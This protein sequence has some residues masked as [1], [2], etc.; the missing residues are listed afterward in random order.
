[1][2][3]S[4]MTAHG[5]G[6]TM[7][8]QSDVMRLLDETQIDAKKQI[9]LV[10]TIPTA[11][12]RSMNP[13]VAAATHYDEK[14]FDW[15]NSGARIGAQANLYN[16]SPHIRSEDRVIDFGC[17]AGHL[18]SLIKC[19]EKIGVEINPAA[20]AFATKSGIQTVESLDDIEDNWADTII[21]NH[22]LEHCSDPQ[23]VVSAMYRKLKVGGKVVLA[24]PH[25]RYVPYSA[26]D[27]NKHLY[28]WSAM[29]LGNLFSVCGFNVLD[30]REVYHR[31]PPAYTSIH[32]IFG[33]KLFHAIAS[34]YGRMSRAVTQVKI[35]ASK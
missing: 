27:I 32:K 1:M 4:A 35:V 6:D 31:F 20:R 3:D 15:Q 5:D 26:N 18:L 7:Q 17:G 30:V 13:Q 2:A 25:E 28:T 12:S 11:T 10:F 23:S 29:N 21:S 8:L 19:A 16:F 22:A 9:A 14:Y 33:R 34:L 24:V